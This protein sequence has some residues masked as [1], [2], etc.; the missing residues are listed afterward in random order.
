MPQKNTEFFPKKIE[1]T[2]LNG[3]NRKSCFYKISA[4]SEIRKNEKNQI[5]GEIRRKS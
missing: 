3:Y 5:K 1:K 4:E 2:V